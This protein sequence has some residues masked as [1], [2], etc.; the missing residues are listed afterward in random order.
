MQIHLVLIL[1]CWLPLSKTNWRRFTG[2]TCPPLDNPAAP[3]DLA[4]P[5]ETHLAPP[6]VTRLVPAH[7]TRLALPRLTR[8]ALSQGTHLAPPEVTHLDHVASRLAHRVP[9]RSHQKLAGELWMCAGRRPQQRMKKGATIQVTE[10]EGS[11]S[12]SMPASVSG[13]FTRI[14]CF[15]RSKH[16][17]PKCSQTR[18]DNHLQF[19]YIY[20]DL[21]WF[22]VTCANS[23]R[24]RMIITLYLFQR[25]SFSC[26][27]HR[28]PLAFL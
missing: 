9:S 2:Q 23:W 15:R 14:F 3:P 21:W 17:Y 19:G 5:H 4:P 20:L 27:A 10:L 13:I 1:S 26:F 7:V 6:H 8:L 16:G 11:P 24:L 18:K 28:L 25:R 22:E 12:I